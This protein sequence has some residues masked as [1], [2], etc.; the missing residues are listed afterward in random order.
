MEYEEGFEP[1]RVLETY[2]TDREGR[3]RKLEIRTSMVEEDEFLENLIFALICLYLLLVVSIVIVNTLVLGK[4]WKPFYRTLERL[5]NYQFGKNEEKTQKITHIDE[6]DMLN[7][8]IDKMIHRNEYSFN[9]QKQ[10][11]EN[12]SHELQTPLA[13]AIN[14]LELLIGDESLTE[15]KR[16]ELSD[17]SDSLHRLVKLNRSLLMLSRIDNNQFAQKQLISFN[18]VSK[19]VASEFTD[20]FEYKAIDFS[21][22]EKQ[23]F[24]TE[25]NPDLAYILISN[26]LRNALKHNKKR[27]QN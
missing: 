22:V 11:I 6:F 1:Y 2:F 10:F 17:V 18:E 24:E 14:K 25:M 26:L 16:L 23:I 5:G 27:R 21:L 20:L 3:Y 19:K 4:V 7:S 8:E 15:D 12:A 9:Q 13:I